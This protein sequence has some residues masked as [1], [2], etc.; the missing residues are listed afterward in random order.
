MD[1]QYTGNQIAQLRKKRN[2]TQR[3]LAEKL[4]VTDKAVSKWERGVNFPDLGL[5]EPLAAALGTTPAVLLG[6]EQADQSETL[7]ALAEISREQL[8]E[9]KGDL[10]IFSWGSVA[11]A[12]LMIFIYQLAQK[13][14]VEFHY[15]FRAVIFTLAHIGYWYLFKY[16]EMKKWE[17]AELGTFYGAALPILIWLVYMFLTGNSLAQWLVWGLVG[18]S[19]VFSQ[20]H[21]LQVMRPRFMQALPLILA[22][23]YALWQL[24]LGAFQLAELIPAGCCLAVLTAWRWRRGRKGKVVR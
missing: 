24:F 1:A 19:C 18:I 16:G 8:E 13:D 9:A 14:A 15:L 6:L 12:V 2:L 23:G 3:E 22:V 10:R 21:F 11:V 17:P 7:S 20:V 4:H 5:L